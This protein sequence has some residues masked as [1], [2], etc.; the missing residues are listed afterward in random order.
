MISYTL[1]QITTRT[2]TSL[3]TTPHY[4][5]GS[6]TYGFFCQGVIS[7][8]LHRKQTGIGSLLRQ[9]RFH[10]EHLKI[11]IPYAQ[12][13]RIHQIFSKDDVFCHELEDLARIFGTCGYD[14]IAI[15]A[16][17]KKASAFPRQDLLQPQ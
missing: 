8:D 1:P 7:T 16:A 13:L 3:L 5:S 10:L 9:L 6:W 4:P 11:L 15:H 17:F 2:S 12:A 14:R